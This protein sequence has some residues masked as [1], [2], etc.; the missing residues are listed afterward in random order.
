MTN[1]RFLTGMLAVALVFGVI[2]AGC[3]TGSGGGGGAPSTDGKL[4]ITGLSS[5]NGKYAYAMTT[6]D[7][8]PQLM[9]FK[10]TSNASAE[11]VLISSGQ[12]VLSV[13]KLDGSKLAS[14]SGSGP[15]TALGIVICATKD[16]EGDP[17]AYG[18]A[19]VTFANGV[20]TLSSPSLSAAE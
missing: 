18:T 5:Y 6:E 7:S 13:Y 3:D 9:C 1:K 10:A 8:E 17:V 14:Y 2:L 16:M 4:T 19:N 20:G 12:V 11:A 15:V